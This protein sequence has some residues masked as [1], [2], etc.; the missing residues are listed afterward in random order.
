MCSG[1]HG[2]YFQVCVYDLRLYTLFF[3]LNESSTFLLF[4]QI[5]ELRRWCQIITCLTTKQRAGSIAF[6]GETGNIPGSLQ[7]CSNL[8]FNAL[9]AS[10]HGC[11]TRVDVGWDWWEPGVP[12]LC[13]GWGWSELGAWRELAQGQGGGFTP[14]SSCGWGL[15][16]KPKWA[17]FGLWWGD[18]ELVNR[19]SE[20]YSR[21]WVKVVLVGV[22]PFN[23][24][25]FTELLLTQSH[26]FLCEKK[27]A[28]PR[29]GISKHSLQNPEVLL[30]TLRFHFESQLHFWWCWKWNSAS[31]SGLELTNK[32]LAA[33]KWLAVV[34][35]KDYTSFFW[36]LRRV[37]WRIKV[38]QPQKLDVPALS[39]CCYLDV[40]IRTSYRR[41]SQLT[42]SFSTFCFG[43]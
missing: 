21:A 42:A 7:P 30:F 19:P 29:W 12:G 1:T 3:P 9:L 5:S 13:T 40:S 16:T 38:L 8:R 24:H 32:G 43:N 34:K 33:H 37:L 23:M 31:S 25:T 11:I 39:P 22:L 4:Q 18:W 26:W 20:S 17:Q 35:G 27:V 28:K 14:R 41:R 36:F 15:Q 2:L 6:L 10:A